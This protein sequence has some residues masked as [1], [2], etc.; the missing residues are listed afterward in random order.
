MQEQ[1]ELL[2]QRFVAFA[3]MAGDHG[4]LEQA[5]L[6]LLRI[7]PWCVVLVHFCQG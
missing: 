2:A 5:L 4:M 3:V 6:D 7:H 1:R